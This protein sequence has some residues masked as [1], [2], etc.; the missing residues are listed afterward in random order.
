MVSTPL[1][2]LKD[3][4][5]TA[6][7][8]I[9]LPWYEWYPSDFAG[10]YV[11]QAMTVGQELG[12]RRLLDAAWTSRTPCFLPNDPQFL[13]AIARMS[14]LQWGSEGRIVLEMFVLT[15]DRKFI[16]HPKQYDIYRRAR[17]VWEGRHKGGKARGEQK[18]SNSSD[19]AQLDGS[20]ST[21]SLEQGTSTTTTTSTI[22][23]MGEDSAEAS[24]LT[25]ILLE[26]LHVPGDMFLHDNATRALIAY[27]NQF[28][29]LSL[30]EC[31]RWMFERAQLF[32][33]VKNK[34]WGWKSWFGEA[35][36]GEEPATWEK[37]YVE[38]TT[39]SANN[40]SP[41]RGAAVER[42]RNNVSAAVAAIQIDRARRAAAG[43]DSD[44]A[45]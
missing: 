42:G 33:A 30:R 17:K 27:H 22:K 21:P 25:R 6:E 20:L 35:H 16:Y 11:V 14:E 44:G 28:P 5:S 13:S 18:H 7:A 4:L 3:S 8:G 43:A 32:S 37:G 34:R 41:R 1:A 10:S 2:Q 12:Y 19:K 45:D 26:K 9:Q 15:Q 24:V 39:G 36:Y 29:E 38:Q 31:A 40:G 23:N